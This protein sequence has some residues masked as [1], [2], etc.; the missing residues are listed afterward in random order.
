MLPNKLYFKDDKILKGEVM[1]S[2]QIK[3]EDPASNNI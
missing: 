2:G 3:D 1:T